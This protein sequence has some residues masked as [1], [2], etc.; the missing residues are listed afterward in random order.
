MKLFMMS[1]R[2]VSPDMAV[3]MT[4]TDN[5]SVENIAGKYLAREN[6]HPHI[7]PEMN[8]NRNNRKSINRKNESNSPNAKLSRTRLIPVNNKTKMIN[9]GKN[10]NLNE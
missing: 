4:T 10:L 6:P 9:E 3:T 8:N 7:H 1:P 5:K 2:F